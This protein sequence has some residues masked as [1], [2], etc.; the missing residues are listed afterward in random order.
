MSNEEQEIYLRGEMDKTKY[1]VGGIL[2]TYPFG[3]GIGHAIQGRYAEKGWI[4]T[5]GEVGSLGVATAS[6]VGCYSDTLTNHNCN[7]A[8]F[9]IGV[10]AYLGFRVWEIIDVWSTPLV[11]DNEYRR[12][13]TKYNLSKKIQPLII[14]T[15]QGT[16]LGIVY[17]F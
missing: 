4:F 13:R 5:A 14:P 6:L 17:R 12:I 10:Y 7:L 15:E 1:I 8:P 16:R 9:V 2:G 3:L 11:Q